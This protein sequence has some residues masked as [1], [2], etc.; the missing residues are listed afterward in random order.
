MNIEPVITAQAVAF[1]YALLGWLRQQKKL[2]IKR[3][4]TTV[5]LSSIVGII[6]GFTQYTTGINILDGMAAVQISSMIKKTFQW[7]RNWLEKE[8]RF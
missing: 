5:V 3:I 6:M 4:A 1:T 7:A 8:L 2:E